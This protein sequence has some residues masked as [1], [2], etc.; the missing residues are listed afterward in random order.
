MTSTVGG[1]L[2]FFMVMMSIA[3]DVVGA[4][5]NVWPQWL[6]GAFGW[7]AALLLL[8]GVSVTQ[9]W[10][11]GVIG[12][13][14][15]VL[16]V[17]AVQGGTTIDIAGAIGNNAGLISMIISVGF[18][19]LVTLST[20]NVT[21]LPVGPGAYYKTLLGVSL[22]G[23]VINISAPIIFADRLLLAH[24][25]NRLTSQ[26]ITRI[27]SGC[28]A[29]SPFFG[30]MAAVITY[31]P[32]LSLPV[33]MLACFPFAFFGFFVVAGEARLRYS[34]DLQSFRGYPVQFSSL[35]VPA[36]LAGMVI[37]LSHLVPD[38][39]VLTSISLSALLL[40]A[41]VLLIRLGV[42]ESCAILWAQITEQVPRTVNELVLFLV[43]GVLAAG[44][45]GV[46][47]AGLVS[48]PF[49]EFQAFEAA[50]LLGVMILLAV[51][52][53]HPLVT[54]SGVTPLLMTLQPNA[55]LLAI[56]FLFAWS[57]G[58]CASPLSGTHLVFQ[59][60]YG[61]PGW[62]GASWNWPYVALMYLLAV[63]MLYTIQKVVV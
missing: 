62:R 56:T 36:A 17:I 3:N 11:T 12:L 21:E 9:R 2:L 44:I 27:F 25:L 42:V 37:I 53:V 41:V 19:R 51:V 20:E 50:I 52:G 26:S 33:V 38:W 32:T 16:L 59:G 43:A 45:S 61:I 14:G 40:S 29:W 35:W 22:F 31:V 1:L 54:I 15:V 48:V 34:K 4:W 47:K 18:L 46:I 30:G 60:R 6:A 57:L 58:T 24:G 63:P 39:S 10:Q 13:I 28:S 23:S 8:P 7:I 49:V 55:N 5:F